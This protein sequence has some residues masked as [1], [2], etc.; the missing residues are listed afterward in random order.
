MVEK[1]P[2]IG[3]SRQAWPEQQTGGN[4]SAR[5]DLLWAKTGAG[6]LWASFDFAPKTA[7]MGNTRPKVMSAKQESREQF[8]VTAQCERR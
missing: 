2:K 5:T 6:D 3:K 1:R 8:N 4:G 7:E